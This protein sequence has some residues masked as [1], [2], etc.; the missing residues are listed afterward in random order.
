VKWPFVG[1]GIAIALLLVSIIFLR[2]FFPRFCFDWRVRW[3]RRHLGQQRPPWPAARFSVL[4]VILVI[5]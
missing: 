4:V 3:L 5:W 1:F 2:G